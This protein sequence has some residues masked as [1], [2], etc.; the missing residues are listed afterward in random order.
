MRKYSLHH[1]KRKEERSRCMARRQELC[2]KFVPGTWSR[3]RQLR[4]DCGWKLSAPPALEACTYMNLPVLLSPVS[5]TY[6]RW[7]S[8]F[9]TE[10][11]SHCDSASGCYGARF[12]VLASTRCRIQIQ[13]ET[14]QD[15]GGG[16]HQPASRTLDQGPSQR[17]CRPEYATKNG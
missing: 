15:L 4:E 16:R 13:A 1:S 10:K 7:K 3:T 2:G 17:F 6:R 14:A 5:L 11:T 9:P 8:A 12:V